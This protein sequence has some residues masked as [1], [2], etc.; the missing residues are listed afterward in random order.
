MNC[1]DDNGK[2]TCRLGVSTSKPRCSCDALNL[3][4]NCTPRCAGCAPVLRL[5]P[6]VIDTGA[7]T[8]RE[9]IAQSRRSE[10]KQAAKATAWWLA[11][12]VGCGFAVGLISGVQ[13]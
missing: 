3:C 10:L 11:F 13:P 2:C 1:C 6:G 5:A 4:Q 8:F 7:P 9:Q 12:V